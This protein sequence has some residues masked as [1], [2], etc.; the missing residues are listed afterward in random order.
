LDIGISV[1]DIFSAFLSVGPLFFPFWPVV[2]IAAFINRRKRF[3]IGNALAL[4]LLFLIWRMGMFV[5]GEQPASFLLQEPWNTISFFALGFLMIGIGSITSYR[6]IRRIRGARS[7]EKLLELTPT[8]F[9]EAIGDLFKSRGYKVTHRGK[10]G[11][12]GVDLIVKSK[13]IGKWVVQCK[14]RKGLV[15]EPIL[16]DVYGAMHHEKAQGAA[17]VTTGRFSRPAIAWA[18]D[19]PIDLYDG[20]RL[21]EILQKRN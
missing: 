13:K 6:K 12:H 21:A 5:N 11:D 18:E 4:W 9:E 7:V 3:A 17:V 1:S 10:S 16:R 14:Q 15:G 2:I 20:E 8:E 19:K